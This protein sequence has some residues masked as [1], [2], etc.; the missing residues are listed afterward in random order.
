MSTC[1]YPY[2]TKQDILDTIRNLSHSQGLYSRLYQS[3]QE[4]RREDPEQYNSFMEHL[5]QQHF[6]DP[7]DLIMYFEC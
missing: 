5:Q 4:M 7:V 1:T 2:M 3:L 6:K